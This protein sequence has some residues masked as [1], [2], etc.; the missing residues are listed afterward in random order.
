[1]KRPLLAIAVLLFARSARPAEATPEDEKR[2]CFQAVDEAQRLHIAHKLVAARDEFLKCARPACPALFRNDCVGWLAEVQA[3]LPSVVFGAKDAS[4]QDLLD[5][6]V[7]VDGRTVTDRL[8]GTSKDIDPGPHVFRFE[9]EGRV[10]EQQ[11]VMREG[12]KDR[13]VTVTF[14][15]APPRAAAQGSRPVP[16]GV[17]I[18][19][20]VAVAGV[21]GFTGLFL[22][23]ESDVNH[24]RATCAPPVGSGCPS[25][26]VDSARTKVTFAYVS[27]GVGLA[28]AAFATTWF[29][30]SRSEKGEATAVSVEPAPGGGRA[31]LRISF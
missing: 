21:A 4:G 8:E 3:A 9:W 11:A 27:L 25:S 2:V 10:V 31:S 20:G 23:T 14:P 17:W 16:V 26:E 6:H 7:S 22:S 19:G 18:L 30:L 1:V 28:S 5:V 13:L 29:L 15:K 24:L 12:E